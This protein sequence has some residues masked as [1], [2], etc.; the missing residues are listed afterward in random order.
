MSSLKYLVQITVLHNTK[1][2]FKLNLF[3]FILKASFHKFNI[4]PRITTGA[5]SQTSTCLTSLQN[6]KTVERLSR[7]FPR[8]MV[9]ALKAAAFI[10]C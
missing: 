3:H 9:L 4:K 5:L 8:E 7:F 1:N 2:R 6:D 10:K